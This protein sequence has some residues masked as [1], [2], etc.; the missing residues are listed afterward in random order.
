[1]WR[2]ETLKRVATERVKTLKRQASMETV[3]GARKAGDTTG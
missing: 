3:E 1:M 2:T